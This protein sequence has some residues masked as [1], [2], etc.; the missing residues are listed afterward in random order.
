M[1]LRLTRRRLLLLGP[2]GLASCA[3]GDRRGT[4]ETRAE[5]SEIPANT[6]V[7][8]YPDAITRHLDRLANEKRPVENSAIPPRHLDE[9]I[10]PVSLV[11]RER[12]VSG[13]PPAD[14]I[15][16][17]DDPLIVLASGVDWLDDVE[18]VMVLD[19]GGVARAYPIQIMTWHEIVNDVV[20]GVDIAVTFCPLCNSGVAYER[21]VDGVVLD[22]GTSGAL[23]QANLVMYDRQSE[24]LWTQFDGRCV[25]GTAA[26]AQLFSRPLTTISWG[27]FRAA[28]PDGEVLSRETGYSKPYGRNPY[29]AYERREDPVAGFYTGE[30]DTA[31]T[32]FTRVIGIDINGSD[33][34]IVRRDLATRGV[35]IVELGGRSLTVW[36]HRGT[37]SAL[38]TPRIA[39]GRDIG[40]VA[41][42][43][44]EING[45]SVTFEQRD[46][47]IVDL[48]SESVWNPFGRAIDGPLTGT[49]LEVVAHHDTFWF[50]WA[51]FQ[52]EPVVAVLD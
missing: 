31:L 38:D 28:H 49:Q 42:F 3:V 29:G 37:A 6:P 50:A 15:P 2:L 11:D 14:G 48:G 19:V 20:G 5:S 30:V 7:E 33:V 36:H 16:S 21:N 39:D 8:N 27:D 41:V 1:T 44:A 40:A 23:Y 32:P 35:G 46:G 24:S 10:F 4:V 25:L 12:I 17:I 47:M 51:T 22:F 43:I 9:D 52:V 18:P 13:G 26:G 45:V 34:A